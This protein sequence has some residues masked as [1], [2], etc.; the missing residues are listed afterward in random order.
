V[1]AALLSAEIAVLFSSSGVL[2]P[3]IRAGKERAL[4]VT[5]ARRSIAA[6]AVSL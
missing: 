5:G 1:L 3:H 4:A 2:F 6:P